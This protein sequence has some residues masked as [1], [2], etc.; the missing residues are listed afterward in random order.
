MVAGL[1]FGGRV[2][3]RDAC[4]FSIWPSSSDVQAFAF[5]RSAHGAVQRRST[6][7]GW[8]SQSLFARFAVTDHSGTWAGT[9]VL[10][11]HT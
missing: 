3:L 10:A 1:G 9:D 6:D 8:M 5:G 2:P 11:E 7:E 4:T